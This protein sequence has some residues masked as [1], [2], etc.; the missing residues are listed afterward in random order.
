MRWTRLEKELI[1]FISPCPKNAAQHVRGGGEAD[2]QQQQRVAMTTPFEYWP[3]F[4]SAEAGIALND[5]GLD[6]FFQ[7]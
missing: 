4:D 7:F 5:S 3:E 1:A 6:L 2:W